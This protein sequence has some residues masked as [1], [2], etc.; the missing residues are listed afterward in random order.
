MQWVKDFFIKQKLSKKSRKS[1]KKT[2]VK[3]EKIQHI[4][5]LSDNEEDSIKAQ[6]TISS[7]WEHPIKINFIYRENNPAYECYDYEDFNLLGQPKE[8]IKEF[9][10]KPTDIILVTNNLLDPLTTHLLILMP[11][12]YSMGF[13]N[14]IHKNYLDLMLAKEEVSLEQNLINLIKYLKK[15]N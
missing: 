5:I 14:Q 15:I 2:L 8:K 9:I 11:T 3:Y 6:K 12:V 4:T 13:Y 7:Y 1:V 10:A